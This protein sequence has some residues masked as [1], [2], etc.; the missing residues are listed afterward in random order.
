MLATSN[1]RIALELPEEVDGD[2]DIR[3]DN[4]VI[5]TAA[6]ACEHSAREDRAAA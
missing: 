5:R 2:V 6:R 3:V 4:G 1:G